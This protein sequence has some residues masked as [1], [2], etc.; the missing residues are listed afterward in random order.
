MMKR[1]DYPR[2]VRV[3]LIVALLISIIAGVIVIVGVTAIA[4]TLS[5]SIDRPQSVLALTGLLVGAAL[6]YMITKILDRGRRRNEA[7]EISLSLYNEIADRSARCLNDY[8]K[9]LREFEKGSH[10]EGN[11]PTSRLAKFRP[12][13]P[14]VYPAVAG[15]LG[16]I[17]PEALFPILQFY[18]RLD[19]VRREIDYV[20]SDF[21]HNNNLAAV[22]LPRV[23]RVVRRFD[24]IRTPALGALTKLDVEY[25]DQIDAA[26]V[27]A[28][29]HIRAIGITLREAL[30][31]PPL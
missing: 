2:P 11:M 14:V 25:A 26:A 4:A 23:Q 20:I 13:D 12:A 21:D 1:N 15:K 6:T 3:V 27:S 28:Y 30:Q 10:R 9:P 24:E 22:A 7:R 8:I 29:G 5:T 19:A 17:N 16:L 31:N 18:F